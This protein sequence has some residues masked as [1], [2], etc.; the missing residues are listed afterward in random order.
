MQTAELSDTTLTWLASLRTEETREHYK[1]HLQMFARFHKTTPEGLLSDS[2]EDTKTKVLQYILHLKRVARPTAGKGP[3]GSISVNSIPTYLNGVQSFYNFYDREIKWKKYRRMLP[4][5]ATSDLR[6][7]ERAEIA[8]LLAHADFRDTVAIMLM[9]AAGPRVGALPLLKFKHVSV[10]D[11]VL[12][13]GMLRVY[14][15]SAASHY[16]TLLTPEAMGAIT[17]Y[18]KWR[19]EQGEKITDES[20]LLRDKFSVFG[21]K[22]NSARQLTKQAIYKAITRLMDKA[23]IRDPRLQPDHSFRYFFDTVVMNS[24]VKH[25][26]KELFMG[27]S[28]GLDDYYYDAKTKESQDKILFEYS[29]AVDALTI[30]DEFRLKKKIAG[31]EK[32]NKD[33]QSTADYVRDLEARLVKSGALR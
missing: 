33:L 16:T 18:K 10:I 23:G 6:S 2:I 27:H 28:V 29:K 22:R 17:N 7:Y 21:A 15:D 1:L 14:A 4:E 19:Q 32:E 30:N 5:R 25:E 3:R 24:D 9:L 8:A 13:I 11:P 31:L 20:W 12:N 26:F